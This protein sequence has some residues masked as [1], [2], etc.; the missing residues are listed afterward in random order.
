MPPM[1]LPTP[2]RAYESSEE[3]M[4]SEYVRDCGKCPPKQLRELLESIRF[5]RDALEGFGICFL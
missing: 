1:A 2:P 4:M 3:L 5:S